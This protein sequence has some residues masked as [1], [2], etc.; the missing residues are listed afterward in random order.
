MID[1]ELIEAF[2]VEGRELVARA[3]ADLAMLARDPAEAQ[4]IDSLFRCLHTLKGSAGL[5][6]LAALTRLLH[7][8]ESRLEGVR[9]ARRIEPDSAMEITAAL[10]LTEAWLDELERDRPP[11]AEL[12][13]ETIALA[14]RFEAA[15]Q[16]ADR[17]S[18]APEVAAGAATPAWAEALLPQADSEEAR[19]AVRYR[20]AADAYFRGEDPVAVFRNLPELRAVSIGLADV[21]RSKGPYDPFR[22]RLELTAVCVA[23]ESEVRAALRLVG[24]QAEV[25]TIAAA[26][27]GAAEAATAA[28]TVRVSAPRLDDVAALVDEL[29]IARNALD[30]VAGRV[31]A[32]VSDPDLLREL[33]RRQ[34][35]LESLVADLYGAV[36]DLRL[37][38]LR[39][40][41][42][43][44]PRHVRELAARLGKAVDFQVEGDDVVL[45][46]SVVETLYEPLLH[47]LRNAVDH[48]VETPEAR[49]VAGKAE[50]AQLQLSARRVGDAVVLAVADDGG[51]VDTVAVREAA[52]ARG[53]LAGSAAP[54]LAETDAARLVFA[55]GFSTA[56]DVSD[57][58]G[59]GIGMDAV[60][61]TIL[62]LGGRVDLDNQPGRGLTVSL[63]LPARVVLA[64]VLVVEVA[65]QRFGVP[66]DA[67]AETHRVRRDE[68][69][70]I[71]AGRAYVRRDTVI[72]I[73]RLRAR[74]G[75]PPADDP[76]AFPVL[77]LAAAGQ[78]AAVQVDALAERLDA[79]LRPLDGLLSGYPGI[80]GSILQGDGEV[81]LVLDLA[82][83]CS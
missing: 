52:V 20:P 7:A 24:D 81:L 36:T 73:L 76:P 79:P 8:A 35:R 55:Q 58:S 37:V 17:P 3:G 40:L 34:G 59:R 48:G 10:D 13:G 75:L 66:L 45:D 38:S 12:L 49:R 50:R 22:C 21:E 77:T 15:D 29:V 68:V 16:A 9:A 28:R 2:L 67:V 54:A 39:G 71:R 74:L 18:A 32:A 64:R 78:P 61:A 25:V 31:A 41:F 72:P 44:F 26:S 27:R 11:G 33:A 14:A 57:I 70:A 23:P 43:R 80:V 6:D 69:T 4:A 5:F 1:R 83:L 56:R 42:A 19:V 46:K 65:G 53:L 47:L 63:T 51:G 62:R 82:E 30:H 60:Q